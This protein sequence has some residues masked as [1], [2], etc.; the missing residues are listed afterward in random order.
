VARAAVSASEGAGRHLPDRRGGVHG[1]STTCGGDSCDDDSPD[2]SQDPV[3]SSAAE[4]SAGERE[5]LLPTRTGAP[6]LHDHC[7][8]AESSPGAFVPQLSIGEPFDEAEPVSS[9][10]PRRLEAM[11]RNA[12]SSRGG[13]PPLPAHWQP[14]AVLQLSWLGRNGSQ[15]AAARHK[16]QFAAH[17][18][19]GCGKDSASI[20][21]PVEGGEWGHGDMCGHHSVRLPPL[22]A[23]IPRLGREA[24]TAAGDQSGTGWPSLAGNAPPYGS[25]ASVGAATMHF[26]TAALLAAALC[27]HS[28]LEGMALGAQRDVNGQ[29]AILIAIAGAWLACSGGV[30]AVRYLFEDFTLPS[31]GVLMAAWPLKHCLVV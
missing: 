4:S 30:L 24:V 11:E 21:G 22:P 31:S 12:V 14:N 29:R 17:L 23:S 25:P 19:P 13:A 27:V 1:S 18:V 10:S 26:A 6:G 16:P 15:D 5:T 2:S 28:V 8:R 3:S 7:A 20:A 9:S